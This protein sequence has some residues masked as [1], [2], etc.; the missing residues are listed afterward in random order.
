[1][2]RVA[3]YYEMKKSSIID[4]AL[5][6]CKRKTVCSVTMQ[7]IIDEAGISQGGIYRYFSNIDE[8]LTELLSRIRIEQYP[9]IDR[10]CEV[11][12]QKS[13]LINALRELPIND[14]S[15]TK[16]RKLCAQMIKD[17]HKVW[18]EEIQRFLYPHKKLQME[19]TILADNYPERARNI[20]SKAAEQRVLD[21]RI[22]D[23]LK[24]EI[25]DGILKPVIPLE[26]FME[27]N[28]SVYGGIIKRAIMVNCYQRN[29]NFNN[30]NEYDIKKRYETFARSS[31]YFLGIA[32]YF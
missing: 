21:G 29:K 15:I 20:F 1:M 25:T 10:L 22:V 18:G 14:D 32:E 13:E 28:A 8:V 11:I 30:N 16:R 2:P 24:R 3:T 17:L 26:E 12:N 4:A 19:F 9:A 31:A 7:D 5:E 27:Y 6:V 23:E